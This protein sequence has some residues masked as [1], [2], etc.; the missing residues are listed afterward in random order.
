LTLRTLLAYLDDTLEP[1]EIKQIGQK[2]A[3]SDAAQELIERIKKVTRRRR[4]TTPPATGPAAKFDA[5]TVAEYLDNELSAEQVADLEKVCLESD[6]H[7][8]EIAACHQI[9]TLVLGEPALVPP[10]AK[11]RMYGLVQGREAIPFRKA[12]TSRQA[13]ASGGDAD[14][15]DMHLLGLPFHRRSGWMR[16]ALPLIAALILVGVGIALWQA[17]PGM[18]TNR[19]TQVAL[20][21][22]PPTTIPA[23]TV[24]ADT[25][26]PPPATTAPPSTNVPPPPTT[27]PP[28]PPATGTPPSTSGRITPPSKEHVK[29]GKY[30]IDPNALPSILVRK[31]AEGTEGWRRVGSKDDVYTSDQL[32]SLPG[33]ASEVHLD[34]GVQLLLRGLVREFSRDPVMDFLLES[35]IVLHKNPDFDADLTLDRGRLYITNSRD[36]GPVKVRL[37]FGKD[38]AEVWDL[39]LRE[40]GTEIG[41]DMHKHYTRDINWAD[42]E[43]PRMELAMQILHGKA[44]VKIRYV[45]HSNLEAPPGPCFFQWENY[46]GDV[47]GPLPI[48]QELPVWK[49]P[50]PTRAENPAADEMILATKELALRMRSQKTPDYYLTEMLAAE[51]TK[52]SGRRLAIYCMCGLD[53]VRKMI[54]ALGD[55]QEE[56][57]LERDTA[58]FSLR[59]WLARD[60]NQSHLLF[61][62]VKKT[63]LLLADKKYRAKEAETLSILLHDFSDADRQLKETY[64]ALANYLRRDKVAIAELAYW[65]LRRIAVGVKLPAF[66]A[67]WPMELRQPVADKVLD[68]IAKGDLPPPP[69][70]APGGKP[71]PGPPKTG[72]K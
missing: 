58:I 4:L 59:R 36:S 29:A 61:D 5:N 23:A 46:G 22:N 71:P 41:V 52:P 11:E 56:H 70:G 25:K 18:S 35:A 24:P 19:G 21:T 55:E 10:T 39:T 30:T 65:H 6:V 72:P 14:A 57:F 2:A 64:E 48:M 16:W 12:T 3:E 49:V 32:M 42:G 28:P 66:N 47:R 53:E 43:D 8:A 62:P 27:K 34:S 13:V 31:E 40:P 38:G 15:D 1:A 7:L 54:D 44:A 37:R 60:A 9:L 26:G 67:A 50:P 63:G 20:G 17:I 45:T 51:Q 68:F 69:E 33:Y